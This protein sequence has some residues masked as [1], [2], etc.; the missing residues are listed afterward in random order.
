MTP[1]GIARWWGPV[2]R[3][4]LTVR[5]SFLVATLAGTLVIGGGVAVHAALGERT[6][7]GV[8]GCFNPT[9]YGGV[10]NDAQ[11]DRVPIQSALDDAV[12]AGGGTVCVNAGRWR[13]SRAPAGSYD[14]HA[15][16]STHGA[17]IAITG[18]GPGTV[19]DLVGDQGGGATAVISLDP[20]ATD[21]T[22]DRLTIDTSGAT[23]TDEQTHAIA[24]GSG[25]CNTANGTCSMPVSDVTV[26]EVNFIHPALNG[27]RKGDCIRVLGNTA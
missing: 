7:K 17:H 2:R 22:V 9:D 8:G 19:L 10:P 13:L 24:I 26:R 15:A 20:G 16:L 21:I 1:Q 4:G 23:N 12:A 11:D 14:N 18:T 27:F 25:I 3:H 5:R 6:G